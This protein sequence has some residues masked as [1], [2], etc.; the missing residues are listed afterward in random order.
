MVVGFEKLSEIDD[1]A[2]RVRKVKRSE[3]ILK[4]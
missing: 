1:F 4:T 3:A 2:D